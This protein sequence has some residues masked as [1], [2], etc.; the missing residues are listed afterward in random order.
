[1]VHWPSTARTGELMV[2]EME[3]PDAPHLVLS[4]DLGGGGNVAE[5]I[6]SRAAGL[7]RAAL[8]SGLPLTLLTA[9]SDGPRAG[10]VATALDL[11]RR[12]AKATTGTPASG[13][14]PAGAVV[15]AV[16]TP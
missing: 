3:A 16:V 15:V 6:A 14:L 12:L 4:V 9:E 7:G 10:R 13:P 8:R 5:A 2:R 1:M 11:G